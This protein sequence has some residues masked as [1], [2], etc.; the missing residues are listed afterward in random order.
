M[1]TSERAATIVT[2]YLCVRSAAQA[3]EFYKDAFGAKELS[4]LAEPN[5]KIGHAEIAIGEAHI[6]LADEY[7]ELE[8][9]S[10]Q[11]IG[12]SPVTIHLVVDDVDAIVSR[13]VA[14]GA[15]IVRPVADQFYGD[16]T[17]RIQDPFG[18]VWSIATHV[19]DVPEDEV[20]RRAAE[21]MQTPDESAATAEA[22][23]AEAFFFPRGL[24][25]VAPYLH[26]NGAARMIDFLQQAFFAEAVEVYRETNGSVA[27]AKIRI[28]DTVI[29]MGDAREAC[30]AMSAAFHLFVG[31][32]D[33]IHL[34]AIA[35]GA[36][37]L[38]EPVDQP[39]GLREGGIKDPFGNHWYI[40]TALRSCTE[41]K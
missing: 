32:V 26:V 35:A 22:E 15:R 29:E 31:N 33:A 41:G 39:Y 27:H 25:R 14:A 40:A 12:G 10:P 30:S 9:L 24:H 6:M 7:P 36:I 34:R 37:S 3:I 1:M 17:G 2:P 13:A 21:M 5:G 18:H 8:V 11:S 38:F 28:E 20:R 23:T 16:R 19:G 4:R